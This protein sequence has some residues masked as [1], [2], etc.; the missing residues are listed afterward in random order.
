MELRVTG[1]E[2][3]AAL[4]KR[5]RESGD[6]RKG[7]KSE[8]TKGIVR[9]TKPL[10]IEAQ[11]K[12][13]SSLPSSGGL[14]ARVAK[15]KLSTK[16]L[17]GTNPAVKI[18]ATGTALT[19]DRGYVSHPVFGNRD[20]WVKQPVK[21]AGWFSQTMQDGAPTVRR[22]LIEAMQDIADKIDKGII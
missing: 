4:A 15:S 19:T 20:A 7:L 21:G 2:D 18:V 11:K 3:L 12:A 10:R 13:G 22:E 5:I 16:T 14:A 8:L 9:A 17:T 1:A 6:A